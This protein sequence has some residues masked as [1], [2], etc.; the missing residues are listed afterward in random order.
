MLLPDACLS[1]GYPAHSPEQVVSPRHRTRRDRRR[2]HAQPVAIGEGCAVQ[3][4]TA[5]YETLRLLRTQVE[6]SRRGRPPGDTALLAVPH[7][8]RALV[9]DAD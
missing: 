3:P 2:V 7:G 9:A 8:R 5:S 1:G 4:R 6:G